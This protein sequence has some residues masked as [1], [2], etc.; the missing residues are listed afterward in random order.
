MNM[1]TAPVL[2]LLVLSAFGISTC[3]AQGESADVPAPGFDREAL[4]SLPWKQFDQTQG[5]G[6]RVYVNPA[7]KE[8]LKAAKLIEDYLERHDE[9]SVRQRAICHYHAAHQ[10]IYRAVRGGEGDVRAA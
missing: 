10:Y 4:L 2:L 7:R 6:W 1:A 5:S 9:L 3:L 8:Y